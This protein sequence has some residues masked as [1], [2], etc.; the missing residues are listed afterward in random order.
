MS[1]QTDAYDLLTDIVA[2][3]RRAQIRID[4]DGNYYIMISPAE[5]SKLLQRSAG[6]V[7]NTKVS[8]AE[9]DTQVG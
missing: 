6:D 2:R 4:N 3:G 1:E 7:G 5:L 9:K 8:R